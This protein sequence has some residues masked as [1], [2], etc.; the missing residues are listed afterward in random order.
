MVR[1]S[2]SKRQTKTKRQSKRQTKTKRQS[3]RQTKRRY[4]KNKKDIKGGFDRNQY[5]YTYDNR[6]FKCF[7]GETQQQC[8][9]NKKTESSAK[10]QQY[11]YERSWFPTPIN[12]KPN[13]KLLEN[14]DQRALETIKHLNSLSNRNSI[15]TLN[16]AQDNAIFLHELRQKNNQQ[17]PS[18]DDVNDDA[19]FDA[20]IA[21]AKRRRDAV[22]NENT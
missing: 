1:K 19:E 4:V 14:A 17:P 10:L 15:D 22:L 3:K 2:K 16:D 5:E 6:S 9:D 7:P 8:I 20:R 18:Y 11:D 13:H 12:D 21:S